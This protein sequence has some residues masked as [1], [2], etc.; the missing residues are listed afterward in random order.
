[1]NKSNPHLNAQCKFPR[2]SLGGS[3]TVY[4]PNPHLNASQVS[5]ILGVNPRELRLL[6]K[7][8]LLVPCNGYGVTV[9]W[10]RLKAISALVADRLWL[11]SARRIVHR[12]L[13]PARIEEL[14]PPCSRCRT[15]FPPLGDSL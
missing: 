2:L 15:T 14:H 1:M 4:K 7:S 11:N 9:P 3:L 13:H 12:R 5:L 6:L 8:G 10:F